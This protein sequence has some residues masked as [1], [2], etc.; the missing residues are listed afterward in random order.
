MRR[1]KMNLVSRIWVMCGI[2]AAAV[3]WA[4]SAEAGCN[5]LTAAEKEAGWRLLFDGK[6][7][8][9]WRGFQKE[10]F[11]THGWVVEDGCLKCEKPA[12]PVPTPKGPSFLDFADILIP[13]ELSKDTSGSYIV[14]GFGRL[15]V[16]GRVDGDS[17]EKFFSS[18][19]PSADWSRLDEY[20]YQDNIKMF[21]MKPDK[22]ASIL[23]SENPMD[24]RV[25]IW[26][27]QIKQR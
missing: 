9:G 20:R 13:S 7:T 23:I 16:T 2:G 21:F 22:L 11:P 17:I 15:V 8:T 12:A 25:E 18:T 27:T 1:T 5:E 3:V 10:A 19:M 14:N 6:G 4:S 26:V 24:T